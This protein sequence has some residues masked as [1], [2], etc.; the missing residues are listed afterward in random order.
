METTTGTT[1][2]TTNT[3]VWFE[4]ESDPAACFSFQKVERAYR[5]CRK[6][7]RS[8]LRACLYEQ[9][10]LD[11]L[12][13]T[14]RQLQ[15]GFW[16]PGP[17]VVFTVSKPKAREIYAA[18]FEDRVVHHLLVAELEPWLDKKFIHDSASNRAGK[19]THFAVD[20]LQRFMRRLGE[21]GW[22]LQLDIQNFFNSIHK[23]TLMQILQRHIDLAEKNDVMESARA[24]RVAWLCSRVIFQNFNE[25]AIF[26]GSP[27]QF[28]AVPAHK[29]LVNSSP[30]CGLPIGNLT[31]Q[32]FANVYMNE[33]DQFIK[34]TLRC[35]CYVR[36]VDDFVL[37]ARTKEQLV[38][39]YQ[40]IECFLA[41]KLRLKLKPD[42][43]LRPV[44]NGADFLGYIV[45]PGYRLVRKR[46]LG[47]LHEKVQHLERRVITPMNGT[48]L[49]PGDSLGKAKNN[50]E[51]QSGAGSNSQYR[52]LSLKPVDRLALQSTLAS[53]WGH[54]RH[55]D[56]DR[57]K[58]RFFAQ[59]PWLW[60]LFLRSRHLVPAWQPA[61]V[62]SLRSQ[63]N[64]FLGFYQNRLEEC[65]VLVQCGN[66]LIV[67]HNLPGLTRVQREFGA[68]GWQWSAPMRS[69]GVIRVQLCRNHEN[70]VFC[71]E[72]G[73]LKG[74]M[75]RR[76][77]RDIGWRE[78]SLQLS[79]FL[80]VE[81]VCNR[82]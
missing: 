2:T 68:L 75:K 9:F 32:F 24:E 21:R 6:R 51:V 66:Q 15:S 47:N 50:A 23:H 44:S 71:S 64:H 26:L 63:W 74:G 54:F 61:S 17:P 1:R 38:R 56:S 35:R 69:Y 79:D 25:G 73:Y 80:A 57:L 45:R 49:L 4:A 55:A 42:Y 34:H 58:Q 70:F 5:S 43:R 22:Y 30:G 31:S 77:V 20:R 16:Q 52:V 12:V 65:I 36:Y 72:Q 33:L 11:H 78:A 28:K 41:A 59:N 60:L 19:G 40:Q 10:L 48:H 14:S 7:K 18:Q 13:S 3:F 39:W 53:Y 8:T 82:L 46:V 67:S 37:L 81:P 76:M 62:C 29:R 27:E